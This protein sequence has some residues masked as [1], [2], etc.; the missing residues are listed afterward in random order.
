LGDICQLRQSHDEARC[1][2]RA[3]FYHEMIKL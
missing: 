3:G 1:L 2:P